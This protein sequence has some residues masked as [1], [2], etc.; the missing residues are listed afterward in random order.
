M[1]TLFSEV[2]T[3]EEWMKLID[4]VFSNP[5]SFLVM[6]VVAYCVANQGPLLKCTEHEDFKVI[7]FI[8]QIYLKIYH[9]VIQMCGVLHTC[10]F[11]YIMD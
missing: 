7:W 2:L 9:Q 5:P 6:V 8:I 11:V 3:R 4:N 1:E 10:V